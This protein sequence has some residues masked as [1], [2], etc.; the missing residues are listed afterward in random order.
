MVLAVSLNTLFV[1][2]QRPT[3]CTREGRTQCSAHDYDVKITNDTTY[4][5]VHTNM[6]P[7]YDNPHWTN[8]AQACQFPTTYKIPRYPK[9]A[10]IPIPLATKLGVYDNI[11]YLKEDPQ[12]MLGNA[13]VTQCDSSDVIIKK[14][15]VWMF[16]WESEACSYPLHCENIKL[17]LYLLINTCLILYLVHEAIWS[18]VEN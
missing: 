13:I 4:I 3:T 17:D 8:P 16:V 15:Y 11:T 9:D 14:R 2:S 5:Y 7:P 1:E 6:C 12:P 10:S 18:C